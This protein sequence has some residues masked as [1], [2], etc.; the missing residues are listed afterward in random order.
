MFTGI[1][2]GDQFETAVG[3][4][5]AHNNRVPVAQESLGGSSADSASTARDDRGRSTVSVHRADRSS[6]RDG[7]PGLASRR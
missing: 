1:E 4:Q 2:L 3:V 6:G 5:I 7:P